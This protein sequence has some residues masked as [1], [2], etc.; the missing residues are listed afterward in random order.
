MHT[1]MIYGAIAVI[2]FFWFLL[3]GK[4]YEWKDNNPSTFRRITCGTSLVLLSASI[5]IASF[6]AAGTIL[7]WILSQ[8]FGR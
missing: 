1:L 6:V 8:I 3:Q 5:S 2:C 4:I 7:A